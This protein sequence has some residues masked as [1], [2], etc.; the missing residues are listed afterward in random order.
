MGAG[1]AV[2]CGT[3]PELSPSWLTQGLP[4]AVSSADASPGCD[5]AVVGSDAAGENDDDDDEEEEEE[6]QLEARRQALAAHTAQLADALQASEHR[7]RFWQLLLAACCVD[8]AA[9]TAA[10]RCAHVQEPA[11]ACK[12]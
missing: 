12:K 3:H 10:A 9:G 1:V 5:G 2:L 8:F 6:E 4:A 7:Q 11:T